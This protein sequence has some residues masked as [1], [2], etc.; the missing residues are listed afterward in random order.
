MC[1]SKVNSLK[2]IHWTHRQRHSHTEPTALPGPLDCSVM[3]ASAGK[4]HTHNR[5]T[6]LLEYVRDHPGEQVPER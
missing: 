6:A 4:S 5:F 3:I 1:S 2:N